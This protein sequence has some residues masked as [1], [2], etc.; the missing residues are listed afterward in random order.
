MSGCLSGVTERGH[1]F[2][3]DLSLRVLCPCAFDRA[4]YQ[5]TCDPW[6]DDRAWW[7]CHTCRL[8]AREAI[9][10]ADLRRYVS[11]FPSEVRSWSGTARKRGEHREN[12]KGFRH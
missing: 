8:L 11:A 1:A 2:V 10:G 6:C 7:R 4:E 9:L 5:Q 3:V 12:E